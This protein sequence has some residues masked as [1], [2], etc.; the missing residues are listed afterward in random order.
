M[1][2][3]TIEL[4][5]RELCD[6]SDR[7]YGIFTN[8]SCVRL[9]AILKAIWH[10]ADLYWSDR[11]NHAITKIDGIFYDIGGVVNKEYVEL[12]E[13]HKVKPCQYA[14][15]MMIKHTEEDVERSIVVEKYFK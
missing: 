8:G 13:Y 1:E 7:I 9:F 14:G 11:E 2:K 15:Y 6:S 5:L 12:K 10:N 4:F 3:Q